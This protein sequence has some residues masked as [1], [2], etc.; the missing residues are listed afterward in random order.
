MGVKLCK[1]FSIGLAS[2]VLFATAAFAG[3]H[4]LNGTWS[5]VPTKSDF[6]GMPVIQTGSVTINDREHNI[7]ISRSFTFDGG[8]KSTSFSFS[9]DGRENS[10]IREGKTFK[11]KAKW[12]GHVLKVT[13]TQDGLTEVERYSLEPD[14]ILHLSVERAGHPPQMF[15]FERQ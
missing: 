8:N 9:T 10:S 6:G 5:L 13:T 15:L 1:S 4:D 7:Y 12:D 11:S 2:L 14:G 3:H